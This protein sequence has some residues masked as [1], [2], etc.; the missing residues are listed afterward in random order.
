MAEP[1]VLE[2]RNIFKWFPGGFANDMVDFELR[3]GEIH[4]VLG[5]NGAGKTTLM[6]IIY[7]LVAPD[8]GEIRVDGKSVQIQEP[9]DAIALGISMVHQ[10]L[11]LIPVFSVLENIILGEEEHR[12]PLLDLPKAEQKVIDLGQKHNLRVD[13]EAHVRDLPV[14]VQQRVE[15]LKA[16]YRDARILVLDEPTGILTP[17]ETEDLFGV[18]RELSAS[19]ISIIFV[20]HK[21]REVLEVADRITVMRAGKVLATLDPEDSD[22]RSLAEMMVGRQA[23]YQASKT[24]SSPGD[25]VLSVRDLSAFT[26]RGLL[27]F[28]R[29]SFELRAGEI[30]GIAGVQGNGQR[31]LVETLTGLR[32]A[33]AGDVFFRGSRTTYLPARRLYELGIGHIPEDREKVGL[34]LQ[35]SV[36]DNLVLKR[37]YQKPF[38]R[39]VVIE[40]NAIDSTASHLVQTYGIQPGAIH[41]DVKNL[42]PGNQQKVVL[43]REISGPVHLLIADQP[44]HGLDASSIEL[45]HRYL[46]DKRDQGCAIL[47]VSS[48]LD[49]I[50]SI[51]D[52]IAVMY[53][54]SIM[55]E[56]PAAEASR[57]ELG[58][59]M[60][61]VTASSLERRAEQEPTSVE[62]PEVQQPL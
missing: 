35:F 4:A 42:T 32:A 14:S 30:L 27:A 26:E 54:G 62:N 21:L 39:G 22:E 29:L 24:P 51:S 19:G 59:L 56:M 60:A 37:Y 13:P 2:A 61:G 15:I 34:V 47:L 6:N 5:E 9:R 7:G 23:V 50:M 38:T 18:M 25:T 10:E 28:R 31:E 44:T 40:E 41:T 17:Q 52:R 57:E 43:A 46:L 53:R 36:A 20:T 55:A 8:A 49:E 16:L 58:L 33:A 48:E 12:G 45:V 1:I 11:T 3:R